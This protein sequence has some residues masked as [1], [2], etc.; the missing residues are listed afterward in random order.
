MCATLVVW[1]VGQR[2]CWCHCQQ[3]KLPYSRKFFVGVNFHIHVS[4]CHRIK[5]LYA[6]ISYA[7]DARPCPCNWSTI[8]RA[9]STA[10]W[11]ILVY[12]PFSVCCDQS[13]RSL[14]TLLKDLVKHQKSYLFSLYVWGQGWYKIL[15]VEIFIFAYKTLIKIYQNVKISCY[16][17]KSSIESSQSKKV[18]ILDSFYF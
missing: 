4:A 5:Y 9:C 17:M 3:K 14:G 7:R 18:T 6:L 13:I 16:S 15:I 12:D 11:S 2:V 8:E 10:L 1:L